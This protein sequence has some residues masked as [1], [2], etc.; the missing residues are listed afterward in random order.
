MNISFVPHAGINIML[1]LNE[2]SPVLFAD[3]LH[4]DD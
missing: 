4:V 2:T 1:T 3:S